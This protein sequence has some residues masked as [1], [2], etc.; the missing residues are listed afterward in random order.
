MAGKLIFKGRMPFSNY[1][2]G[3]YLFGGRENNATSPASNFTYSISDRSMQVHT[4]TSHHGQH[5]HRKYLLGKPPSLSMIPM[6]KLSSEV[7]EVNM[8]SILEHQKYKEM[9]SKLSKRNRKSLGP[10]DTASLYI[11]SS[12]DLTV[13]LELLRLDAL[14]PKK[15]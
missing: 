3:I 4:R 6:R 2:R 1:Q 11:L 12:K 8:G 15:S 13:N 5:F 7:P 14:S 10:L 9:K